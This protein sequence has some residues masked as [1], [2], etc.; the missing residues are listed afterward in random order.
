MDGVTVVELGGWVAGPSASAVLADWGAEVVKIEPPDGDPNRAWM[1]ECNPAFELD[2]RGKR[3]ITLDLSVAAARR[4]A[5]QLVERADV[6]VTNLRESALAGMGLD[7]PSVSERCPAL[8]YASVTGYG[9]TGPDRDRPA[10]EGGA[11]WSRSGALLAMTPPGGDLPALPGGAGD[12]V[13]AVTAVA[14][15]AAA[16]FARRGSGRGQHV[17]TSLLRAGMFMMGF[18]LNVAARF[19][20]PVTPLAR[21]EARNPLYNAYRT[22]DGAWV[23]LL[24]LQPDRHWSPVAAA[25]GHPEWLD[26]P[27][28]ATREGRAANNR[29]LIA[30]LDEAFAARPLGEWSAALDA[31]GV[32]WTRIQTPLD[33]LSDPQAEACG[34]FVEAPVTDGSARMVASPLDFTGTPWTVR[35][36]A[37]EV[38]EHT[39]EV[40]QWLGYDWEAIG[41]LRGDGVLG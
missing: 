29:A 27:R 11:F 17:T 15:I 26:D 1:T 5:L 19:G 7:Y 20:T 21:A 18:D 35:R 2:N 33:L 32:W 22:A 37:P 41:R 13:T 38:G 28:F 4:I 23:F 36:R 8:V 9:S 34:G 39:E 24:G 30:L 31:H 25:V 6:F 3:S 12:H 10:Y 40:L 14:G 16:L